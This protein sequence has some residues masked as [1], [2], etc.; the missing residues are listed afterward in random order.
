METVLCIRRWRSKCTLHV[1]SSSLESTVKEQVTWVNGAFLLKHVSLA[2]A[3]RATS[4]GGDKMLFPPFSSSVCPTPLPKPPSLLHLLPLR[5]IS[6][7]A[8]IFYSFHL[9]LRLYTL[10]CFIQPIFPPGFLS[11]ST[12]RLCLISV[13][14]PQPRAL[15]PGGA[16][17]KLREM[18]ASSPA[19]SGCGRGAFQLLDVRTCQPHE[20]RGD[21]HSKRRGHSDFC[22]V[23]W[24]VRGQARLERSSL[25]SV[26]SLFIIPA[27]GTPVSSTAC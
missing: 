12:A 20:L 25:C 7:W 3:A 8:L 2:A 22:K 14:Q 27:V 5:L 23:T 18:R 15:Y 9:A 21:P 11:P 10:D 4:S 16:S 24:P 1:C 6:D 26:C 19:V 13:C 17:N